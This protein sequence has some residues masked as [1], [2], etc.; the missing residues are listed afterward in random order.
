MTALS[1]V[2]QVLLNRLDDHFKRVQFRRRRARRVAFKYAACP[3][4]GRQGVDLLKEKRAAEADVE[5]DGSKEGFRIGIVCIWRSRGG[6]W[7]P[8]LSRG[9]DSIEHLQLRWHSGRRE[10][11]RIPGPAVYD[12]THSP[13]GR[14]S[15]D[16]R[17]SK[18]FAGQQLDDAGGHPCHRHLLDSVCAVSGAS[19]P[20]AYF[21]GSLPAPFC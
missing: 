16:S 6:Q 10:T 2:T 7:R 13:P 19:V 21:F 20:T 9:R 3:P 14:T 17:D 5:A 11:L 15:R 18:A 4:A 8:V 12:K 1:F